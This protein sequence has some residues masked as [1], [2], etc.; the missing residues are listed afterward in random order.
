M[1]KILKIASISIGIINLTAMHSNAENGIESTVDK[2]IYIKNV[3]YD[4]TMSYEDPYQPD[5]SGTVSFDVTFPP[6]ASRILVARTRSH[7]LIYDNPFY[8][9]RFSIDVNENA[10]SEHVVFPNTSW[11]TFIRAEVIYEENAYNPLSPHINTSDYMSEEDRAAIFGALD[12]TQI[13]TDDSSVEITPYGTVT[14]NSLIG[15]N[16]WLYNVNGQ[17]VMAESFHGSSVISLPEPPS[18]MYILKIKFDDNSLITR[19]II[20]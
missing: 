10:E 20:H 16:M 15:G 1:K 2:S 6:G 18:S 4:Y 14:I 11:G 9:L 12:Q 8:S 3:V 5:C 7:F 13:N 17:C 19:K